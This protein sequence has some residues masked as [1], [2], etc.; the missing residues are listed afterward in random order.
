MIEKHIREIVLAL[1]EC[2][3]K[4]KSFGSAGPNTFNNNNNNNT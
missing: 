4:F 2:C 1:G 3:K